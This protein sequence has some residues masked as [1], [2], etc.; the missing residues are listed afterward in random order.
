MLSY[1]LLLALL[2]A[3]DNKN[4]KTLL[5]IAT[6]L[7]MLKNSSS[8][9][10]RR[11][12]SKRAR[13]ILAER[14]LAKREKREE[15][16]D[17]VQVLFPVIIKA[18]ELFTA[19]KNTNSNSSKYE[20]KEDKRKE[21]NQKPKETQTDYEN[22]SLTYNQIGDIT[23][24][25]ESENKIDKVEEQVQGKE[26]VDNA[27]G[28]WIRK[29]KK[30]IAEVIKEAFHGAKVN[31]TLKNGESLNGEVIGEYNGFLILENCGILKYVDGNNI[32]SFY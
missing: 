24:I 32:E 23:I 17:K 11:P 10:V 15:V 26:I 12:R 8:K 7:A 22:S 1:A 9:K 5:A 4:L 29:G 14:A 13:R 3:G 28:L 25:D 30:N 6:A 2:Y 19:N 27:E 16:L 31:L 20:K 21:K 18:I